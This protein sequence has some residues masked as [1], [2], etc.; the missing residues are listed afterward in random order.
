MILYVAESLVP[1]PDLEPSLCGVTDVGFTLESV[2]QRFESD[3]LGTMII[4]NT[5]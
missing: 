2:H 5:S 1:S 3:T 4:F